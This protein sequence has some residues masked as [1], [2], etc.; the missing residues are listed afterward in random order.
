MTLILGKL[1]TTE[2]REKRKSNVNKRVLRKRA[3]Y[4]QPLKKRFNLVRTFNSKTIN[5]FRTI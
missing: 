5:T 3:G 4:L 2:M 1:K